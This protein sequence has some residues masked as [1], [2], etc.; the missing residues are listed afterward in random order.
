VADR[1]AL[2]LLRHGR[3]AWNLERRIQG[4]LDAGL[5]ET[6]HAQARA[7]AKEIAPHRPALLWSSDLTRS[8]D[9]AA[10]VGEACGLEVVTDP[11]LREYHLGAM[12]G[13]L[14][15][16][17]AETDPEA[18]ERFRRGDFEAD[19]GESTA[20]VG[21]RVADALRDLLEGT[22]PGRLSVAV[23]HGAA[24]RV[25]LAEAVGW[26]APLGLTLGALVNCGWA[27][28]VEDEPGGRLRLNSYNRMAPSVDAQADFASPPSVG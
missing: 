2:L 7:A 8:V 1:R 5:D 28:L 20:T 21:A 9:T 15:A 25:G 6:G 4:H 10:Y 23:S 12:Q 14:Y 27:V 26:G 11:R 17:V 18:F 13:R 22:P 19:D 16:E 24:I 3:T